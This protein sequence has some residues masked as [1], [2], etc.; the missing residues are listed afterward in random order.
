MQA[1]SRSRNV[2]A[3]T[4]CDLSMQNY[5]EVGWLHTVLCSMVSAS[6]QMDQFCFQMRSLV[7]SKSFLIRKH[8]DNFLHWLMPGTFIPK[9][10]MVSKL[11]IWICGYMVSIKCGCIF[12]Q[13]AFTNIPYHEVAT[14]THWQDK[15][16]F[17]LKFYVLTV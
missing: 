13:V 1:F 4:I 5:I 10:T 9:Y 16:S 17:S 2:D 15:V 7:S 11:T 14:R 6:S 12:F 3:K 8:V